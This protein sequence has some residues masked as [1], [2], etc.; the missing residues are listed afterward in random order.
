MRTVL[1]AQP[2]DVEARL[3]GELADL[4]LDSLLERER[5]FDFL[6]GG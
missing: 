2:D 4:V 6:A 1:I 3:G 5:L